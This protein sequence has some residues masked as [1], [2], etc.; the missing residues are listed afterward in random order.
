M[1]LPELPREL[2]QL[3]AD[4]LASQR[5][6]N[7]LCQTNRELY[8]KVNGYLYWYNAEHHGSDVLQWGA[9]H[10][11]VDVV[12][13]AVQHGVYV[14]T[15]A[16]ISGR[17]L[18]K[19]YNYF[20]PLLKLEMREMIHGDEMFALS[21]GDATPL[22]LAA[23]G[24][25]EDVVLTLLQNG[26]SVRRLG[27]ISMVPL[28]AAAA[29][30]HTGV[31]QVLLENVDHTPDQCMDALKLAADH[32]HVGAVDMLL[33]Y[34]TNP[35][36]TGRIPALTRAATRGH[37]DVMRILLDHGADIRI[38]CNRD[39]TPLMYA[40]VEDL[41]E[42]VRF[43]LENGETIESRDC[44]GVIPLMHAVQMGSEKV[45]NLLLG[46][47][48]DINVKDEDNRTLLSWAHESKHMSLEAKLIYYRLSRLLGKKGEE[49]AASS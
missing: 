35:S 40:I 4:Y 8:Q 1:G 2:L 12:R 29:G 3:I 21:L 31:I 22:L 23:G 14:N 13:T 41:P 36:G 33:W 39:M 25:C 18:P 45:F 49:E 11:R 27:F 16:G 28:E 15:R 47:G 26:A 32:G 7:A 19:R 37:I 43:L 44:A 6:I 10:G 24:G 34:G 46:L 5:D 20:C 48:A 17:E 42:V 30:G 9:I 38:K